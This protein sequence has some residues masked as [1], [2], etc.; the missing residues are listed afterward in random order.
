M[1][2]IVPELKKKRPDVFENSAFWH[3]LEAESLGKGKTVHT[4]RPVVRL[5]AFDVGFDR[6]IRQN[7]DDAAEFPV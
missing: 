7:G 4:V 1:P 6:G 3:N 5:D 2:Y